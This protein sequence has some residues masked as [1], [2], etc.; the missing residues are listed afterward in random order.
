MTRPRSFSQRAVLAA[1]FASASIVTVWMGLAPSAS[2]DASP[3]W[4]RPAEVS[5]PFVTSRDHL[6]AGSASDGFAT[7][8]DTRG[9]V[10][11]TTADARRVALRFVG[12]GRG[13][14]E[15]CAA[16]TLEVH[17]GRAIV[18]RGAVR[19]WYVRAA[20]GL[21][22]GFDLL[23]RPGGQGLLSLSL[24]VEGARP[25]ADGEGVL[26]VAEDGT[27]LYRYDSLVVVDA[28]GH[29][30]PSRIAV[31]AGTVALSVDDSAARYP[32]RI[33]PFVSPMFATLAAPTADLAA[34]LGCGASV[35]IV[36]GIAAVG[37]PG[38]SAAST[39]IGAGAV[40]LF[41][42]STGAGNV[43]YTFLAKLQADVPVAGGRFG[44]AL[45]FDGQRLVVGAPAEGVDANALTGRAYVFERSGVGGA[46]VQVEVLEPAD[47][48]DSLGFGTSVALDGDA[49][50]VG[51]IG[52][53]LTAQNAGAGT[54]Y[55]FDLARSVSFVGEIGLANGAADDGFGASVALDDSHLLVGAP[56]R[57][58]PVGNGAGAAYA[59][60]LDA[61]SGAVFDAEI[62]SPAPA[63]DAA[64]GTDLDFDSST[65]RA[66]V[67][68]PRCTTM[69][70]G[71]AGQAFV[72][73]HVGT[74][75][76]HRQTLS[77]QDG[78]ANEFFGASVAIDRDLLV[79][80]APGALLPVMSTKVG[81][82]Y[83]FVDES[84]AYLPASKLRPADAVTG[85]S[86]GFAVDVD[87][88]EEEIILGLP[89][90]AI[91]NFAAPGT[92]R[93]YGVPAYSF[94]YVNL[95]GA[96]SGTVASS[97]DGL[98]CPS[99]CAA[100][101]AEGAVVNLAATPASGSYVAAVGGGC[102]A[103]PCQFTVGGD[104]S[105]DVTFEPTRG[106]GLGCTRGV[107]CTGGNCVDGVCCNGPCGGG[108]LDCQ[109]C[110]VEA[111]GS[112]DGQCT[113]LVADVAVETEC[114]AA[115][116]GCDAP[117]FCAA[118]STECP[119]DLAQ[120]SGHVCRAAVHPL[121]D[122]EEACNGTSFECPADVRATVGT[123]C[124]DGQL[125]NGVEA[126]NASGACVSSAPPLCPLDT[127]P[128]TVDLCV[129]PVGCIHVPQ[130][131]CVV[132]D[133]GAVFL[134]AGTSGDADVP[135]DGAVIPR[136]PTFQ[137]EGGCSCG[138]A[139]TPASGATS[140]AW[141][142]LIAAWFVVRRRRR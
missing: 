71:A 43:T 39:A 9:E 109:A 13:R 135:V 101:F 70:G 136:P 61:G 45:A 87:S 95:H 23:Q 52:G 113:A 142:V 11:L 124:D 104:T 33:D 27:P 73:D 75:F 69:R 100:V 76:V 8:I 91:S 129:D 88:G 44:H 90:D 31:G 42:Q 123:D 20:R 6:R 18:A 125:C 117:E 85:D 1:T 106:L 133:G 36:G 46:W 68:C 131:G 122:S 84:S 29:R 54:V 98:A 4:P 17:D 126:C 105:I 63:G 40:L 15:P 62:P 2:E 130:P 114:R 119:A 118:G 16:G 83:L 139:G 7:E 50:A 132:V 22:Q 94:V 28:D 51:A 74:G 38:M 115:A 3:A 35:A 32:V 64:F 12:L 77:A 72:Y 25:T 60:T 55:L 26:L 5:R 21:E 127:D 112:T 141:L 96:G 66:V 19:E 134:D 78:A 37:C 10:A 47:P 111:G 58:G 67:G 57:D 97:P 89:G 110:S 30:L 120:P 24:A 102:T 107:E 140:R 138:L 34:N 121:C 92:A 59:F 99:G 103:M 82:A 81:A 53:S 93:V 108:V 56:G 116:A 128:C 137:G 14:A 65:G 86:V 49:V 79:V 48:S 41:Q 80:G